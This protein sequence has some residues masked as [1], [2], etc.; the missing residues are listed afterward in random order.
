MNSYRIRI[1]NLKSFCLCIFASTNTKKICKPLVGKSIGFLNHSIWTRNEGKYE[2]ATPTGE[3]SSRPNFFT[4]LEANYHSF[5]FLWFLSC[6]FTSQRTFVA[7]QFEQ[8]MIK[9][10]SNLVKE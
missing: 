8:L 2:A 10:L 7:L 3:E 9:K 6:S 1:S 4:K 5:S